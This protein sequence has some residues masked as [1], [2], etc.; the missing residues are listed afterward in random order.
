MNTDVLEASMKLETQ[1]PNLFA[2]LNKAIKSGAEIED[3]KL[4]IKV[5]QFDGAVK[6]A[7][8]D[9]MG[10]VRWHDTNIDQSMFSQI[11]P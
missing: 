8:I 1:Y 6:Y 10:F 2:T 11:R 9:R 3:I 5:K 7:S 4:K